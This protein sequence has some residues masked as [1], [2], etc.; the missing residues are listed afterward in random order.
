[1]SCA[2]PPS[3]WR[4][5]RGIL[6]LASVLSPTSV[7]PHKEVPPGGVVQILE[8][9]VAQVNQSVRGLEGAGFPVRR[10]FAGLDLRLTDPF[11]MLDHLG[12]VDYAPGEAKGAPDHPH[13]GFETVTYLLSGEFEHRDSTGG[14][15][16][17]RPG[18]T[19]WMTAGAGIVHSEM[20]TNALLDNGGVLHGTQLWVNLPAAQKWTPPVY[21]DLS[22]TAFGQWS[23]PDGGTV[24]VVAGS[25]NAVNGPG[26]TFTPITYL[27]LSV[28]PGGRVQLPWTPEF[29]ALIY[30]LEGE[31]TV[32]ASRVALSAG[33]TAVMTAASP[34]G[35]DT[36]T[37]HAG[38]SAESSTGQMEALVLG[39][40]PIR[41]QIAWY[42][43]F[44]MNTRE[45][46][47]QAVTDY[48]RG[49]MGVIPPK[50]ADGESTG[51]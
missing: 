8:R 43:P 22:G 35:V 15:G 9:D 29:N 34:G 48:Q 7:V 38:A 41:E 10:A 25:N 44:V 18:D 33:Q 4:N 13:R 17:L 6:T 31:G 5:H 21:Q 32:G 23:S 30:V 26:S 11:L 49:A 36:I 51:S 45:E 42:G 40:V 1:M 39:G 3:R 20:P 47:E 14:G 50:H 12:A 19:Q 37:V 16:L 27:H 28:P 46:I 2:R 24:R